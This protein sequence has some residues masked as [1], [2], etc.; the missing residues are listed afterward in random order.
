VD[1]GSTDGSVEMV[2]A[3]FPEARLIKND[4]N[5]GFSRAN[6]QAIRASTTRYV[7]LLN[8]DT[9]V[10]PGCL[11]TLLDCAESL[12]EAG[13]FGPKLLNVDGSCQLG[14]HRRLP[15][16]WDCLATLFGIERVWPHNPVTVRALLVRELTEEWQTGSHP[17]EEIAGCAVLLRRLALEDVGSF[18]ESCGTWFQD[19]DLCERTSKAGWKIRYVPQARVVHHGGASIMRLSPLSRVS[20]Y[21][22]GILYYFHKHKSASQFVMIKCAILFAL[23][24]RFLVACVLAR[25]GTRTR[26]TQ[27]PMAY[28]RVLLA[29]LTGRI[30]VAADQGWGL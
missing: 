12:P 4:G 20:S 5:V 11:Q 3:E 29:V 23:P 9:I 15:R 17:I 8:N 24:L 14:Y 16:F 7:L 21:V 2:E 28:L 1:N 6:N 30:I 13:I 10:L 27:S 19:D 18:D 25:L 22:S 26:F